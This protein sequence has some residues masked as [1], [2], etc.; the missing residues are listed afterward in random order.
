[1][2][3]EATTV[4]H[5]DILLSDRPLIVCDVDEVVLE[6]LTPFGKYLRANGHELLPRSFRLTGNIVSLEN[7]QEASADRVSTMLEDFFATQLDWQTPTH[8]VGEIL[9]NL[10]ALAD[11]LFLTAMPPR[12]YD[13][14]RALLDRHGLTYPL[15]ATVEAKGPLIRDLH[16]ERTQPL[17]F[18]DDMAYN[19]LS[20]LEHAPTVKAI[21]FM[22]NDH[23]RTMAPHPGDDV[24]LASD[25]HDIERI[26]KS[27][28]TLD[29]SPD[30]A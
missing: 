24:T 28:V 4:G 15:I 3:E 21:H 16:A 30:A 1:M 14:R 23:F 8:D 12:H 13:A 20:V 2:S 25:W 18:I 10:S 19:H 7:Q 5:L 26:I 6:F 27:H 22:S 29:Q 11:I 17:V 9:S